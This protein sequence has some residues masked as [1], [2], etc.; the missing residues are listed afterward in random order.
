M[1]KRLLFVALYL[2]TGGVEKSL[3]SL[4]SSLDYDT[5]DVDLLLFDHSGLLFQ[6]VPEKVQILPPLFE[7]YSTPFAAA[8]PELV[9]KRHYRLLVGKLAAAIVAKLSKGVGTRGRWLIYR[10][11]LSEP[12]K[13]YDT[14]IS[15]L[16]FF[17]NY[18]VTEKVKAKKKI[19]YNHMDYLYSQ[20]G[21]WP[22]PPLDRRC[23]AKSRYIV[24]VAESA[25]ASLARVFPEYVE[26][27]R[28]IHNTVSAQTITRLAGQVPMEYD[29]QTVTVLT[30]ARLVEEK[31]LFLALEACRLLVAEGYC[32]HWFIIGDGP[33][34]KAL[35]AQIAASGLQNHF[36]LLGEKQ[37]PY[38]YMR[39][40][41][42]YV[43][44]S[45]TEAHCVAVEEVLVLQRPIIVT[46]IPAFK[47][48]I[49]HRETGW[50]VPVSAKGLAY[51]IKGLLGSEPLRK[52]LALQSRGADKRHAKEIAKFYALLEA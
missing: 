28:V 47:N 4:L 5:Y 15:Y 39:Y 43:Q 41:D 49:K 2:R 22:C 13:Q 6:E 30:V 21:G 35:E 23:F 8:L 16:D 46:D 44:P 17:C 34:L 29:E 33:L 27:M 48:Q 26:K 24:T 25:K 52:R 51:G 50:S 45:K 37:N 10:Q 3:L 1:K 36:I 42:I 19:V 20:K 40:C 31:G 14:A 11:L 7:T 18:Y 9:K 12:D 38:P 32:F